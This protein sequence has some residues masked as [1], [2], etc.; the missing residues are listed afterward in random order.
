MVRHVIISGG[1]LSGLGKGVIAS[2]I[3]RLLQS[4]GLRV[5]A[6]KI[7]PYLNVDAGTMSPFE[8]GEVYILDDA[9]EADLDLGNYERFAD[10]TL[11]KDNNLTT[12]KAYTAVLEKERQGAYLGKTVQ[13]VPHVTDEIQAWLQRA[14][15]ICT[16]GSGIEPDVCVVELGGTVGDMESMPFIEALRQ[17][18]F[19]RGRSQVCLVHVSLVPVIGVVGEQKTK[20]TQQSVRELRGLGLSPD[21]I[22][23]RSATPL[24]DATRDKVAQFCHIAPSAVLGAHD[25][26][27][28]YK[29][30]AML[31]EQGFLDILRAQFGMNYLIPQ[32]SWAQWNAIAATLD[33]LKDH[34]DPIRIALVGKYTSLA[35]SYL[36][37][38]RAV[39]HAAL[40]LHVPVVV[41]WHDA[42]TF[43]PDKMH[44][45]AILIPGGFGDRGVE[46][47][48]RAAHYARVNKVPFLGICLGMQVAVIEA[49]RQIPGWETSSSE[50]F[51]PGESPVNAVVYMPEISRTHMGATMRLGARQSRFRDTS[52]ASVV[53]RLYGGQ[54][55]IS[56]RH[57]HRYEVSPVVVPHIEKAGLLTFVAQDAETQQRQEICEGPDGHPYYVGVQFHPEM[58]SRPTRPSPVFVGLVQA[59]RDNRNVLRYGLEPL[60]SM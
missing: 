31:H 1:V 18:Q 49:A 12:G 10:L 29:V 7:D 59:A 6:L 48:I 28:I 14:G 20:P 11:T 34:A 3:A 47:M 13:V 25:V 17:F 56:E 58:R 35:D 42:E 8:H 60:G 5:T 50:E 40:A 33:T 54:A 2:S 26:S 45:D 52:S 38:T 53:R 19:A 55:D 4:H 24:T 43:A 21:V 30:P 16:D 41:D 37:V 32:A 15:A 23:C 27:N 51:Q 9:G 22:V 44:A 46:G 39:E 57:R 36:S